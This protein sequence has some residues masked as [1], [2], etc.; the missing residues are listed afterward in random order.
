MTVWI[1]NCYFDENYAY[2]RLND[3][4]GG[5]IYINFQVDKFAESE[6]TNA[7]F[8]LYNCT[9]KKGFADSGSGSINVIP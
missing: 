6:V 9:F 7:Q 2:S 4:E 1:K 3:G 5:H 8:N